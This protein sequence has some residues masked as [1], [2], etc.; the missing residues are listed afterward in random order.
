MA[1]EEEIAQA[2]NDSGWTCEY[3]SDEPGQYHE[4]EGCKRVC[5]DLTAAV[6]PLVRKA[7]AEA[8]EAAWWSSGEGFNGEYPDEGVPWESSA[9]REAYTRWVEQNSEGSET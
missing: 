6:M 8:F 5:D 9:G 2:L 3:G 7:Q 4:C 1:I